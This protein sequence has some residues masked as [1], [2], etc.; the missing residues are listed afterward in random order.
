MG[1]T[2]SAHV[3]DKE[4]VRHSTLL[5]KPEWKSPLGSTR[6]RRKCNIKMYLREIALKGVNWIR[7]ALVDMILCLQVH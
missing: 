6:R 5:V 7:L 3:G 2:C 4:C 1:G